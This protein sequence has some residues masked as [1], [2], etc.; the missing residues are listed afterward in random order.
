MGLQVRVRGMLPAARQREEAGHSPKGQRPARACLHTSGSEK[1]VC[2]SM[3]WSSGTFL[4][5]NT[6]QQ[7]H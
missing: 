7:R 3:R 2:F 5:C 4:S 1:R 6:G